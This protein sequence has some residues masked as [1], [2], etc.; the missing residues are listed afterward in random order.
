M[1]WSNPD[2]LKQIADLE[3]AKPVDPDEAALQACLE[4]ARRSANAPEPARRATGAL[5]L[6]ALPHLHELKKLLNPARPGDLAGVDRGGEIAAGVTDAVAMILAA[7]VANLPPLAG[8]GVIGR[9]TRQIDR[10]FAR[11]KERSK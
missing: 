9:L 2:I 5:M 3:A 7:L 11:A 1:T 8:L 4:E 6:A 10:I